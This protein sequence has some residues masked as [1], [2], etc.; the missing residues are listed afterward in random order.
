LYRHVD[1]YEFT[2]VSEVCTAFIII[3]LMVEAVQTSETLIN[4]Y[5][6]TWCYNPEGSH[7]YAISSQEDAQNGV[8]A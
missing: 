5:Q 3:A 7:L 4:S 6:S 1:W 8:H 2:S